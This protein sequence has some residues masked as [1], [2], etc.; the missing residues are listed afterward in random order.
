MADYTLSAKITG[1]ASG[2]TRAFRSAADTVNQLSEKTKAAGEKISEF[3]KKTATAGA[4]VTA[5]TLPILAL[6]KSAIQTGMDFES[7]MSNVAA[8]SGATGADLKELEK[9]AREMGASTSKSA[10]EAA[11]ALSYMALAGWDN[12]QMMAGLEPILRLSEAGSID[13]ARASDLVTDSMSA[14]GVEVKD[15]PNYLDKVAKTSQK[16][17]TDIDT[18]MTAF[19]A[20]G[21]TLKNLRTPI[22]ES[23]ALLGIM[24][25]RGLKGAEAGNALNS[26]LV[27]L[28]SGAGQAGKA[29]ETLGVSAFDSQGNFKGVEATLLEVKQAMAGLNEEQRTQM[30]SMIA[31][32]EQMKGFN[33]LLDGL[34]MEYGD[35]KAEIEASDGALSNMAKTMQDNLKGDLSSLSSALSELGLVLYDKIGPYL[36]QATQYLTEL[37]TKIGALSPKTQT[38]IAIMAGLAVSIGP[39]L[40]I[41][42]FMIMGI[43]ALVSALGFLISP[44]GLVIGAIVALGASFAYQMAKNEA[45]RN[46]V[47]SVFNSIKDKVMSVVQFLTPIF[48]NIWATLQPILVNIGNALSNAFQNSGP[49]IM[50]ALGT[51]GTK[52]AAVFKTVW[53]IIQTIIPIFTTFFS[54]L[55]GGFQSASGVGSG[56][57]VQLISIL[58]GLNPIVKIVIMLFQN[59]GPQ[60]TAAF[61]EVAAMLIPVVAT[62]G[63]AIGQ[64]ASAVI[65]ILMQAISTLIPIFMQVGMTIMGIVSTVLPVLI[66]L[67]NQLVPIIMDVVMIFAGIIAQVVPLVGVLIS[68]LLPVIQSVIAAF[69]NIVQT[70][71]PAL[72]AIIGVIMA[73]IKVLVPIIMS[74]V[75]VVV[76]IVAGIISVIS[77]LVAFVAGII[78]AIMAVIA[79]IIVFVAGV[80]AAIID[81]IRPIVITV[82]GIFNTVFTVI[83]GVF[84]NVS[85]FIGTAI[86]QIGSVI[87]GLT[88]K[89]S[90]VFNKIRS[91]ISGI[92]DSVSNKITGVFNAIQG[93]WSGLT[94]FVSGIFSG[95][96]GNVAKLVGQV[97]GFV[98]GVIGGINSA[99]SLINKIPGVSI[100]KIP[101]LARGTDDFAGGFARMNEGG[102]GELVNLPNGAQVIPHDVSMR[103]AREAAKTNSSNV[104][105]QDRTKESGSSGVTGP[106]ELVVNLDSIEVARATYP[107]IDD[108]QNSKFTS[109]LIFGG[110][111]T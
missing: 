107:H 65:P 54:S 83:S 102:R 44:I 89:V 43:G 5:A 76:Q 80:I 104:D 71:A 40:M 30:I 70:V 34:G 97:K 23:S 15:L 46:N 93:A 62:I 90:D 82:T 20:V 81:V 38:M 103:Y 4:I 110:M 31:G 63:T 111:K 64:L 96:S 106:I 105:R 17:N 42:G 94:S 1:D 37:A 51:I 66:S 49:A 39:V 48:Q 58:T 53:G 87:S 45:F 68:A 8:I 69:M 28:T 109:K 88:S 2:F 84:R 77:P 24:A 67:F 10:S 95:I 85:T 57:I 14:L 13:L 32:K 52:I 50:E 92:M 56:F 61:S 79:P 55:I 11:D 35:L 25:N 59:F 19:L 18:L 78:N 33:F 6:G 9:K 60:I 22:A 100:G 41:L 99:I 73:V 16:A 75:T 36:R 74:I 26:I 12:T 91:T 47:I 21:G 3:G 27:N 86:N 101:Y 108:M 72:I 98:N 29:M 7:S